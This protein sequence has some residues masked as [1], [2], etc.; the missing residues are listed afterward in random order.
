MDKEDCNICKYKTKNDN[1]DFCFMFKEQPDFKLT[2]CR[3]FTEY[4]TLEQY[5]VYENKRHV[6]VGGI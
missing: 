3:Y 2:F 1:S 6:V 4:K 5:R